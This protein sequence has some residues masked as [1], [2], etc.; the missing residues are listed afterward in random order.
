MF[1]HGCIVVI[2]VLYVCV[3]WDLEAVKRGWVWGRGRGVGVGVVQRVLPLSCVMIRTIII[4][5]A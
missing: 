2:H 5:I 3:Y 1:Y 4:I